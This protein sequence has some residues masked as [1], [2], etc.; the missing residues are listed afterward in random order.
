MCLAIGQTQTDEIQRDHAGGQSTLR[1][2]HWHTPDTLEL[3][4]R[5]RAIGQHGDLRAAVV[6]AIVQIVRKE[7]RRHALGRRWLVLHGQ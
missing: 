1:A 3:P 6:V 2:P 5:V 7:D 4:C